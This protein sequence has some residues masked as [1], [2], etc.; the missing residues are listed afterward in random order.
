MPER[1]CIFCEIA[2]GRAESWTVF[3][4][5][6]VKAFLDRGSAS[7]GHTL[8]IP[9][10]HYADIYDIPEEPLNKVINASKKIAVHFQKVLGISAVNILHAS[11]KEAQQSVFHFHLHVVPRY[12]GDG[13]NLWFNPV[14]P[15]KYNLDEVLTQIRKEHIE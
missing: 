10:E 5:S 9:K 1:D 13:L 3:E 14:H 2:A 4:D 7:R 12:A 8:V 6:N 11:R 15:S